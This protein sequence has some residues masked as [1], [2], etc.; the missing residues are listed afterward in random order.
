[1]SLEASVLLG[2]IYGVA[3]GIP[4]ALGGI[5]IMRGSYPLPVSE[6]LIEHIGWWHAVNGLLL[7]L[8]GGFLLGSFVF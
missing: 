4:A 5:S 6:W 8:I 3:R 1:V 2:L 7:L